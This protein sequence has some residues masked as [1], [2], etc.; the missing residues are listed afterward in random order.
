[1]ASAT[2]CQVSNPTGKGTKPL[3]GLATMT[4]AF[5][6]TSLTGACCLWAKAGSHFTSGATV[7]AAVRALMET[8]TLLLGR[9][10]VAWQA[11]IKSDTHAES[12][13]ILEIKSPLG[14]TGL[15]FPD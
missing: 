13:T 3:I 2:S 9:K 5:L 11:H 15:V 7:T 8:Q 1:M 10:T 14:W 12:Q 4:S 6:D